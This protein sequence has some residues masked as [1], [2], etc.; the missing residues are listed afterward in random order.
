MTELIAEDLALLPP[1]QFRSPRIAD[2]APSALAQPISTLD[3]RLF[4]RSRLS[5]YV[6]NSS[7]GITIV[8]APSGYGKSCLLK[9]WSTNLTRGGFHTLF[10]ELHQHTNAIARFSGELNRIEPVETHE[11][12]RG[13]IHNWLKQHPQSVVLID[14][15]HWLNSKIAKDLLELFTEAAFSKG[16]LALATKRPLQQSLA[17]A[18]IFGQVR[19]LDTE[20]LRFTPDE[21]RQFIVLRTGIALDNE[22]LFKIAEMSEGWP[23]ALCVLANRIAATSLKIVLEDTTL[24]SGLMDDFFAEEIAEHLPVQ[25]R[26]F[27]CGASVIGTT[28][29]DVCNE[30]LRI[31]N[32]AELIDEAHRAGLF[33]ERTDAYS[34][35]FRLHKLFERYLRSNFRRLDR[36]SHDSVAIAASLWFE[37]NGHFEEAF[38]CATR[39]YAWTRAAQILERYCLPAYKRGKGKQLTNMALTLPRSVLRQHPRIAIFAARAASTGRRFDLAEDLLQLAEASPMLNE[40]PSADS[41]ELRCLALHI[42][43]FA[44]Q[45]EDNQKDAGRICEELLAYSQ[46]F[47]H[48]A[49][50]TIYGSLLYARREQFK[51][52]DA[53][54]LEAA[55]V[56]EFDRSDSSYGMVWHLSVVGPTRGLAGDLGGSIR[57][58]EEALKIASDLSETKWLATFPAALL[59]EAYYERNELDRCSDLLNWHFPEMPNGFVDQYIAAYVTSAKLRFLTGDVAGAQQWIDRGIAIA[60]SKAM[61]R[62]RDSLIG[63]RI[64]ILLQIGQ[65]DAA[66]ALAQHENLLGQSTSF[67]PRND[68]TTRDEVKALSWVRLAMCDGRLAEA[69]DLAKRWKRHVTTARA[70]RSMIR[71]DIVLSLI[72]L[73]EGAIANAQRTLRAALTQAA[74]AQYVRSFLDEGDEIRSLI[75]AQI[76]ASPIHTNETDQ[77]LLQLL[78]SEQLAQADERNVSRGAVEEGRPGIQPLTQR[79]LDILQMASA[80]VRNGEIAKRIGISEGSVKWYLQQIYDKIG[81]RRR[82]GAL[83]R[84]RKLGLVS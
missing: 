66:R 62:L 54:E 49:R 32:S 57:R 70:V 1:D 81:I 2:W 65:H 35:Q 61:E 13:F 50:G 47:D 7:P 42:R 29:E 43:M 46:F 34:G 22:Q 83:D 25:L 21:T 51:L 68:A 58:L 20:S 79:Q 10:I 55:G 37:Q 45:F 72:F 56:R 74:P 36:K 28:H 48:Y 76:F 44:A 30:V 67:A 6:E 9:Q 5:F 59:A 78:R 14:N 26:R 60:E 17:R 71:W 12:L 40:T 27:L 82:A 52:T 8:E 16:R 15:W 11:S 31:D 23:A 73:R 75:Q 4:A 19:D 69:A 38:N 3:A 77:F 63:E 24:A 64:R 84:A 41:T 18:R 33:I 80:G 53:S 39:A